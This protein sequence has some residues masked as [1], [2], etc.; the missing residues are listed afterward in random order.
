MLRVALPPFVRHRF[1]PPAVPSRR[2]ILLP[3]TARAGAWSA[4][5]WL[6]FV[7]IPAACAQGVGEKIDRVLGKLPGGISAGV[8]V[9]DLESDA[10]V[11]ERNA[12]RALLTASNTKL[13]TTAA[14]IER[15]GADFAYTTE[16]YTDEKP[17]SPVLAG[18]VVLV[19]S[20]D[21][22][23]SGRFF[24][25]DP[26]RV[27]GLWAD[28]LAKQGVTKISGGVV[29]DASAIA[30][31]AVHPDWPKDQLDEWYSAPVDAFNLNDNCLE[32][33]LRAGRSGKLVECAAI[34]DGAFPRLANRCATSS[35]G[36]HKPLVHFPPDDPGGPVV[37]GVFRSDHAEARYLWTARDPSDLFARTFADHLRRRGIDPGAVTVSRVSVTPGGTLFARHRSPLERVIGPINKKSQNLFAEC[38]FHALGRAGGGPGSFAS[39]KIAVEAYLASIG[40]TGQVADGS[41]L[42]RT[43]A[44]PPRTLVTILSRMWK[45]PTR[46]LFVASLPIAGVDGSL[47]SRMEDAPAKGNVFA[48]TGYIRSVS[49]LSGYARTRSGKMLAFSMLFNGFAEV[50]VSNLTLKRDVQDAICQLLAGMP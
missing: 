37:S 31:P 36:T 1:R 47:D 15:L 17:T 30:G 11:Y 38:L 46:D 35:N 28:A 9:V 26:A 32:I 7:A 29:L 14:A 16:V 48:K 33:V 27:L 34:P 10:V 42:S 41:G 22:C 13:V 19:G 24:D 2:P 44:Y 8:L 43:N 25:G 18:R 12:D 49:A 45:A 50:D 39:G 21:P 3:S 40:A 23:F 20:G 5:A 4:L 6:L